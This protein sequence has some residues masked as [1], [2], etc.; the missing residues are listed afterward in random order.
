MLAAARLGLYQ[1]L[2]LDG[3]PDRAAVAES[4]DLAK[5]AAGRGAAGLVNAVLR[6]AAREG[7]DAL[8]G[9]LRRPRPRRRGAPALGAA[10]AG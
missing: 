3:V 10:V 7:R 6:R 9:P 5:G 8:L 4:V 1:L 2:Y